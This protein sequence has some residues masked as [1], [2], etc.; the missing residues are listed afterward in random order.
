[1]GVV[2]R[3]FEPTFD[4]LNDELGVLEGSLGL[5]GRHLDKLVVGLAPALEERAEQPAGSFV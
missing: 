4:E 2:N 5:V 1:M 3:Q